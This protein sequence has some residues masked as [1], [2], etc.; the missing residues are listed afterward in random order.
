[1]PFQKGHPGYRLGTKNK[2]T[3]EKEERRRAFDLLVSQKWD[4]VIKDLIAKDKKYVADQFI[5]KPVETIE[6]LGDITVKVDL[7]KDGDISKETL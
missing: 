6:H 2:K 5:G 1:M 4:S 7:Y 3:L